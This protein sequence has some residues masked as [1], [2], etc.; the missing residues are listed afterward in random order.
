M[1]TKGNVLLTVALASL[2]ASAPLAF[3]SAEIVDN[4]RLTDQQGA[5]HE[6][7]YLSDMKAVVLLAQGTA[8]DASQK[9]AATIEGLRAKYER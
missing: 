7:Y 5:S 8:C 3:G 9:A 2:L 6:L 4:F 1:K